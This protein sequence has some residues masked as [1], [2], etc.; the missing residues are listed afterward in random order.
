[1]FI[2]R[3]T[4]IIRCS[5]ICTCAILPFVLSRALPLGRVGQNHGIFGSKIAKYTVIYGVYVRFWPTL[6][7]RAPHSIRG[8]FWQETSI[9]GCFYR[10]Q[11]DVDR[12]ILSSI[13]SSEREEEWERKMLKC[14][15]LS[16]PVDWKMILKAHGCWGCE[17]L[18]WYGRLDQRARRYTPLLRG[19]PV[20]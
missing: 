11:M 10:S 7:L 16:S 15:L 9:W 3:N 4:D 14:C 13:V 12:A 17:G 19:L 2:L 8:L 18:E 5:H 1:M 6:P 20:I